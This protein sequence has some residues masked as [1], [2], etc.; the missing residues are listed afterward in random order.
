ML[1]SFQTRFWTLKVEA[2]ALHSG[3]Y[4][5]PIGRHSPR[6]GRRAD[7]SVLA[8]ST[9]KICVSTCTLLHDG[10]IRGIILW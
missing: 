6:S 2:I 5:G 4:A 7:I 3:N 1:P 9:C 8:C 10:T